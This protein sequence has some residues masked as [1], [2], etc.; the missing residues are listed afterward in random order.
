MECLKLSEKL[1]GKSHPYYAMSLNNLALD[2]SNFKNHEKSIELNQEALVISEKVHG[3]DHSDYT[4]SLNNLAHEYFY[5]GQYEFSDSLL[6]E[7]YLIDENIF[8]RNYLALSEVEK[9]AYV[10]SLKESLENL[11]NYSLFRGG[12]KKIDCAVLSSFLNLK[13]LLLNSNI[14]SIENVLSSNNPKLNKLYEEWRDGKVELGKY[15]EL[16]LSEKV[17][18]ASKINELEMHTNKLE[19]QLSRS[20]SQFAKS[21][22]RINWLDIKTQLK[23]NEAL[24]KY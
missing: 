6:L 20:S 10:I 17:Q 5:N 4:L 24:Y 18:F 14:S 12:A 15:Y 9:E 22:K 11:V 7:S 2:Y 19:Q 1:V 21:Q 13:G 3:K 8:F 16:S 23:P